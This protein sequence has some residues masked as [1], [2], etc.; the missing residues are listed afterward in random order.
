MPRGSP[1][2]RTV[3]IRVRA[4]PVDAMSGLPWSS[5]GEE[6]LVGDDPLTNDEWAEQPSL[7]VAFLLCT[8]SSATSRSLML[9]VED[10]RTRKSNARSSFMSKRSIMMPMA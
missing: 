8:T 5:K 2:L 3:L 10:V 9:L 4:S 1:L 7:H 6:E